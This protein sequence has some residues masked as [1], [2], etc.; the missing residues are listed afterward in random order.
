[1]KGRLICFACKPSNG[2]RLNQVILTGNT[3]FSS[4]DESMNKTAK[5]TE[6]N[7]KISLSKR[8]VNLYNVAKTQQH[9]QFKQT[10][11]KWSIK[12]MIS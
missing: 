9:V 3:L 12:M 10:N 2:A 1:M 8:I 11:N 6:L 5:K 4:H 7:T